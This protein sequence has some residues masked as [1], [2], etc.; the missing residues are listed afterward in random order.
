MFTWTS[1][2]GAVLAALTAL[3]ACVPSEMGMLSAS[4]SRAMAVSGGAVT[5]AGPTGYCVDKG[6][7]RDSPTGAFVLLGTCAALTGSATTGQPTYPAILTATVLPGAPDGAFEEHLPAMAAFFRSDPGRAA[8]SRSG[9][10]EDVTLSQVL[11]RGDVLYLRLQ[12]RS[13][14]AGQPVE[15]EYW[16]AIL[17]VRGRIV[18]LS[19]LGLQDRPVP[20]QEKRRVLEAFVARVLAANAAQG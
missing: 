13:A 14:V 9:R 20:T 10:A 3:S 8:L 4:A 19:A 17:Q 11:S 1:K 12:D 2:L 16:R 5:V 6:P 7:S 18:T 15:S